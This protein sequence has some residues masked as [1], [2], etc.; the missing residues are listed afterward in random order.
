[1]SRAAVPWIL[2]GALVLAWFVW[3]REGRVAADLDRENQRVAELERKIEALRELVRV[4]EARTTQAGG[5][6]GTTV[7]E[8]P[9]TTPAP[10]LSTDTGE[11]ATDAAARTK[12]AENERLTALNMGAA[13]IVKGWLDAVRS[14]KTAPEGRAAVL[15]EIRKALDDADAVRRLAALRA[16]RWMGGVELDRVD[17]RRGIEPHAASTEP[18]IRRAALEALA[19]MDPQ[20]ADIGLWLA[21]AQAADR[22]SAEVTAQAI[23]KVAGGRI[24]GAAAEAVLLL[25]RDG[26]DIKRAMVM[27]GLQQA[28]SFDPRVEARLLAIVRAAPTGDYDRHYFFHFLAPRMDPKSDAVVDLLLDAAADGAHNQVGTVLRALRV[29]LSDPQRR[30][31]ADTL[32]AYAENAETAYLL[33]ALI[34]ALRAVAGPEHVER[35]EALGRDEEVRKV[36]GPAIQQAAAAARRRN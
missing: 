8:M 14:L 7:P 36:L 23:T 16:V 32:L 13:G 29:G 11:R 10:G 22:S 2:L 6:Q 1:M 17:F 9:D 30:R 21:E 35:L 28:T 12:Q 33:G 18:T 20:P 19:F 4:Q 25:L 27:R 24:E 5:G 26:T 15:D 3:G 31:V 34:E